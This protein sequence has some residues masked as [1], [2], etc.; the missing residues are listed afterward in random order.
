MVLCREVWPRINST[1]L[2]EQS[3]F[4]ARNF[5]SASLAAASTGGAVSLIFDSLPSGAQISLAD[6]RGCSFTDNN[7]PSGCARRKPGSGTRSSRVTFFLLA[8]LRTLRINQLVAD[9]RHVFAVGRPRRNIDRPLS[10]EQFREHA[11]F[12]IREGHEPQPHV[13]IGRMPFHVFGARDVT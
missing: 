9:E 8:G 12:A 2:R 13:L 6:A 5:T 1:R 3:S 7:V 4:S 10:A 11:D